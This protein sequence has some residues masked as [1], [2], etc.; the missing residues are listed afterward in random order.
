MNPLLHYVRHGD[1]EGRRP[2]QVFDSAWYRATYA[3]PP[4]QLALDHFLTHCSGGHT[5]PSPELFLALRIQPFADMAAAG[6]D[7]FRAFASPIST[8]SANTIERDLISRSGLFDPNYYLLSGSD[9]LEVDVDLVSHFCYWGWREH[10][11][12]NICFDTAWYLTTNPEV[13]RLSINPL[14]HYLT[15]GEAA[16]R[17]PVIYFDPLW[18]RAEYGVPRGESAL[19]HYLARRRHQTVSPNP[20]FNPAWYLERYGEEVGSGRDA[21][22]HYLQAGTY[23]NINPSPEFDAMAYRRRFLGRPSRLFSYRADPQRDNPLIH[24]L[25]NLYQW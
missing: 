15:K 17:R 18:Y 4:D 11:K 23:R 13:A 22:A 7:P 1:R 10:R 6:K 16:G 5:L 20:F 12:P 21:F 2:V 19:A 24:H 14:A 3:V 25:R 8:L 9:L